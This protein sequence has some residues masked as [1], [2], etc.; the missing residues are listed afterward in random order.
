MWTPSAQLC[1]DAT[2]RPISGRRIGAKDIGLAAAQA[3]AHGVDP[4]VFAAAEAL[5]AQ[6]TGSMGLAEADITQLSRVVEERFGTSRLSHLVP[7]HLVPT[8]LVPT[9]LV[10]THLVPTRLVPTY[11][12]PTRLVT[13]HKF[14]RRLR[15]QR[16][17][18]RAA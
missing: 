13:T 10:P 3:R 4:A 5:F 16:P 11:L 15:N 18:A 12:V 7:T 14:L 9:R 1:T 8:R 6:A 17:P 2:R